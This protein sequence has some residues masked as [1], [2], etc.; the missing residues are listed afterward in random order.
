MFAAVFSRSSTA[1]SLPSGELPHRAGLAEV[2]IGQ[3]RD[4]ARHGPRE[5]AVGAADLID[6]ETP[7]LRRRRAEFAEQAFHFARFARDDEPPVVVKEREILARLLQRDH[8]A[9]GDDA[10]EVPDRLQLAPRRAVIFTHGHAD[11]VQAAEKDE[12]LL[13]RGIDHAMDG[14][15]FERGL[16]RLRRRQ[17]V[18]PGEP[19]IGAALVDNRAAPVAFRIH[20]QDRFPILEQHGGDMPEVLFRLAVDDDLPLRFIGEIDD[21]NGVTGR[22]LREHGACRG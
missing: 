9:H 14:R 2:G 20:R 22:L 15:H 5:P 4:G 11:W 8:R 16:P 1:I 17:P 12:A 10:A 3:H 6:P 19:A 7:R 21:R 13:P 18:A